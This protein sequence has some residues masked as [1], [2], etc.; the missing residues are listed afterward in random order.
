[1]SG[2][3][4]RASKYRHVFGRSTKK[5]SNRSSAPSAI[6][7]GSAA[8]RSNATTTS[9]SPRMLGT[10]TSSRQDAATDQRDGSRPLTTNHAQANP[11]YISVNWESSGGGA[12]SVIPL[13]ERGRIPEH[14]PLFRGHTAA[15]LDTDWSP[16]DDNLI[17]SA[18]EDGKV[19]IWKV[20]EDFTLHTDA[21]EP[22]DVSPVSKFTGHSR[23]VGHVLFNPSAE[24]VLA[25][26]S[27]D[28]SI[29]IWDV[30]SSAAKLS[31]KHGD[32]V[33]SLSWSA[34]G[35]LLV[36]T[37]RDKKLRIWDSRQQKPA[38]EQPG[39]PGAKN[40]RSVW[41]GEHDRVA[42]T[43]FSK[44]S[45]RQLGLWDVRTP[46]DP[47]GGF[48]ILDSI[49]GVCMPFWDDGTK[50]LYLAGKGDGNIRYYEYENDKFEYLNAY[51]SSE[52]QRG[53]AFLPKRGVNV[54]ENEV[55][56]AFKTV[57]DTYVEPISFIVPR[58]AEVFQ[59]DIYPPTLGLKPSMS[60]ANWFA[61]NEGLPPKISLESVYEGEEPT[62]LPPESYKPAVSAAQPAPAAN[63][64]PPKKEEPKPAP[65][66][67]PAAAR[68]PPP[69][70][71]EN[72]AS[73]A[74]MANKYADNEPEE[75]EEDETSSFEEVPKPVE[76]PAQKVA[77]PVKPSLVAAAA[78]PQPKPAAQPTL[79][80]SSPPQTAEAPTPRAPAATAAAEG[81]KGTLAEIKSM[82][83]MQ[84]KAM[85]TQSD[86]I[87]QLTAEVD[88]LKTRL[89]E[90]RSD[91]E[92]D[93]RIRRLE[94]ELEEAKS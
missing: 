23:K 88:T 58:R 32:I 61:G 27:G 85:T 1:M 67:A 62:V 19:F 17:A 2:R 63:A 60:A 15:V 45:D 53:I 24:N 59:N 43:G 12:F 71:K 44:M 11:H 9:A 31:L 29:K 36:T 38:I 37:C 56:R 51:Q 78:P 83:E 93:E 26:A 68:S 75:S 86:Q 10:P 22:A 33:Q 90:Q 40:S 46:G 13:G 25:S 49:S 76:R 74:E 80:P 65:T 91:R 30:E 77:E 82:L 70:M 21:E 87:A 41:M 18:S 3:F 66:S 64:P 69:S 79:T 84:S 52:P 42:T 94:L 57:N 34:N 28:Y 20:P 5:A 35:S 6:A 72:K 81:I 7:D 55:M 50:C 92:K 8:H 39:H 48:Q 54:H 89:G 47:I 14:I 4:V 16:F 73:I